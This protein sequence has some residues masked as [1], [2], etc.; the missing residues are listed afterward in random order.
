M[1][2]EE[3]TMKRILLSILTLLVMTAANAQATTYYVAT[4]GND[5]NPGTQ[6]QPL[7]TIEKAVE[8]VAANGDTVLVADGTYYEHFIDFGDKGLTLASQSGNPT[9]CILDCEGQGQG[10]RINGWWA[11]ASVSGLTIRNGFSTSNR[12][13]GGMNISRARVTVSNCIFASCKNTNDLGL[14]ADALFME[15]SPNVIVTGC[16]FSNNG[17]GMSGGA[18]VEDNQSASDR[19]V[20]ITNCVFNN[21]S[22]GAV[23]LYSS[24]ATVTN[25]AFYNNVQARYGGGG[26]AMRGH[27]SLTATRCTFIGNRAV[28]VNVGGGGG[29]IFEGRQ[30]TLTN[31]V[32]VHN[33]SPAT[34]QPSNISSQIY[35]DTQW[36]PVSAKIVNCT[37]IQTDTSFRTNIYLRSPSTSDGSPVLTIVNSIIR[38]ADVF[39]D[40]MTSGLPV[41]AT[42]S[43][44]GSSA[45]SGIGSGAGNINADPR[46]VNFNAGDY[47][48]QSDS[49]CHNTGTASASGLP[50]TDIVGLPRIMESVPDMGAYEHWTASVGVWCVDKVLGSD[51]NP[52][53]PTAPFKT[54]NRAITS[55]S[56]GHSIYIKQGDYGTDRPRITKSLRLFNWGD[57]G[58]ARIGK[59]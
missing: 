43:N 52:G 20:T 33:T 1:K 36:W 11:V 8:Q 45:M 29:I 10:L 5:S 13:G 2:R 15:F 21:N 30:L 6:A 24:I 3:P 44:I 57:T 25:C 23:R 9:A 7:R 28:P 12:T 46:F 54:V 14:G 26:I 53:S 18:L 56:N 58:Q 27:G 51:N 55:A 19:P 32:L 49:P 50:A 22:S 16:T 39:D 38:G 48:L 40:V 17:G 4:T 59:Q 41:S 34:L 31:C 37:L 47:R 42:Y 35:I